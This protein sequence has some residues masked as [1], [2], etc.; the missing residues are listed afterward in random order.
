M[1]W[2]TVKSIVSCALYRQNI[3][4]IEKER[5][6]CRMSRY[7]WPSSQKV[8]PQQDLR[9]MFQVDELP[10]ELGKVRNL[11]IL[12]KLLEGE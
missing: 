4:F 3:L 10:S 12:R 1:F 7:H 6:Q 2:Y 8:R 9:P 11:I 5:R